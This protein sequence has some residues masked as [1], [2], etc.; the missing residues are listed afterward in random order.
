[1]THSDKI[2]NNHYFQYA[3]IFLVVIPHIFLVFAHQNFILNW[4]NTDDAF[5]YFKT[6]QNIVEGQGITFDGIAR[7]NG[8]HPLWLIILMPIF[9]LAKVDLTLPLRLVI[10]WQVALG[11][12]S[13]LI[14][15]RICQNFC[16]RWMAFLVAL[17]WAFTP[18][19]YK[20]IF[21]G[22]TEAGLNAFFITLLWWMAHRVAE[23]LTAGNLSYRRIATLGGIAALTLLSRLD[24]V[25]LVFI[26]GGWLILRFW[27]PLDS[28]PVSLA[29]TLKWWLKM[30]IAYFT[31]L[32]TTLGLYMLTNQ[33]YFGSAMPVS[34]KVKRFWGALK[35]TVYGR[36]PKNF[37]KFLDEFFSASDSVGPWSLVMAPLQRFTAWFA[38]FGAGLNSLWGS[39]LL[40]LL[41]GLLVFML[42]RKHKFVAATFWRWN[43]FPL[44]VACLTQIVYYKALGHIAQKSWYWI[45]EMLF[46]VLLFGIILEVFAR[47]LR[48]LPKGIQLEAVTVLI[49]IAV[50]TLPYVRFSYR[51]FSYSPQG[52]G[53][54]YLQRAQFLEENTEPG[55][56][57]GMT[58]SGSSG[59]F[60]RDRTIVNLDGL[61]NSM[62]YFIHLQKG[63]AGDYL[64]SIG[65]EYMFGNAYIL[66]RSDPYR[67]N[68]EDRLEEFR[69]FEVGNKTLTLF[70]FR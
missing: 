68:F 58:G 10:V 50:L 16:S 25:F 35:Y 7:T 27:R 28:K 42:I 51:V 2:K 4:F 57:I 37:S 55:A 62:E 61:I 38:D 66:Q 40:A 69:E 43:L 20:V 59:Y 3:I 17:T 26:L 6:A 11:L 60:V 21:K 19:V 12:G 46:V 14:L 49:F 54:F 36:P 1:M 45:A 41:I 63:S 52:E 34:G 31:P 9:T 48:E 13:T 29:V 56:L 67:M 64:E 53:Q 44:L 47:E 32:V 39:F 15:Y 33:L 24:N 65:L 18:T 23:E 70:I 22:G 5:Y 30:G 8:F